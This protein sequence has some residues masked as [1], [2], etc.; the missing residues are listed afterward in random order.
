MKVFCPVAMGYY[1]YYSHFR[2]EV[3]TWGRM[4]INV[5]EQPK[6]YRSAF[7]ALHFWYRLWYTPQPCTWGRALLVF[8]VVAGQRWARGIRLSVRWGDT[9]EM[10]CAGVLGSFRNLREILLEVCSEGA[11]VEN[12]LKCNGIVVFAAVRVIVKLWVRF[13]Y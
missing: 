11:R 6:S 10:G 4:N 9:P 7:L 12:C 13:S 8:S 1:F 3:V 5:T 2:S